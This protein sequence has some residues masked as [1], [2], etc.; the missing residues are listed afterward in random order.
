MDKSCLNEENAVFDCFTADMAFALGTFFYK[1]AKA[2]QIDLCADIYANG[3]TLFHFS[4]DHCTAIRIIGC[5]VSGIRSYTSRIQPN[6]C[7]LNVREMKIC[8]PVNTGVRC[9][10]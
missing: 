5:A 9:R 6:S 1:Y 3:R 7:I 4:T 8:W 2:H 10:I